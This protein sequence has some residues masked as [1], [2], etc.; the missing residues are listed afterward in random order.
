M[1]FGPDFALCVRIDA[2]GHGARQRGVVSLSGSWPTEFNAIRMFWHLKTCCALCGADE[3]W[4]LAGDM[5][6]SKSFI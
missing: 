6:E 4:G 2:V 1:S 3:I 5:F